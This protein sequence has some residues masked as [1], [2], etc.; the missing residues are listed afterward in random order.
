MFSG[1]EQRGN[2]FKAAVAEL[3]INQR[4]AQQ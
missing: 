3:A 4:E 1:F 2:I